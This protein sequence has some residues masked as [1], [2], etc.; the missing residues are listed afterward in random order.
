[1]RRKLAMLTLALA[2]TLPA[3][4]RPPKPVLAATAEMTMDTRPAW[5]VVADKRDIA[6]ASRQQR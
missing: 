3:I 2:M 1:M 5:Q 6:A 4:L